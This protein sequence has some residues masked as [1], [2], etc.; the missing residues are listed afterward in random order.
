M[1]YATSLRRPLT[2]SKPQQPQP[3]RRQ[4]QLSMAFESLAA[5]GLDPSERAAV[6]DQLVIL[7][8]QAS[9]I[10]AAGSNDDEL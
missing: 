6:I 9:G 5:Q 2:A 8:L 1:T 10:Q 3:P 7:L 4:R